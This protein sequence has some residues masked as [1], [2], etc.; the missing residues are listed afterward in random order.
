MLSIYFK[1]SL[2]VTEFLKNSYRIK[3]AFKLQKKQKKSSFRGAIGA[4]IFYKNHRVRIN[5]NAPSATSKGL[6]G[7]VFVIWR[8][9]SFRDTRGSEFW[10]SEFRD[11]RG[12]EVLVFES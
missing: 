9:L 3:G 7:R 4:T 6:A 10:G 11:T 8:G 2:W 12:S 5:L 1:T